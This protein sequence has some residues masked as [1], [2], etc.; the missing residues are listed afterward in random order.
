[1]RVIK[2]KKKKT[3]Q[4]EQQLFFV[5]SL[6]LSSLE[7]SDTQVYEPWI[8]ALLAANRLL[9][10]R[11]LFENKIDGKSHQNVL[12]C[13][14]TGTKIGPD[15]VSV[16]TSLPAVRFRPKFAKST[17]PVSHSLKSIFGVSHPIVVF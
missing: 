7:L 6:L 10:E 16:N 4:F 3:S 14:L 13:S 2:K 17:T 15:K 8:R 12:E 9:S 5:S 11:N 1:M